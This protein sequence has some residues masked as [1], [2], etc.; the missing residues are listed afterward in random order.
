MRPNLP[1]LAL[2]TDKDDARLAVLLASS[3]GTASW[4]QEVQAL[5]GFAW[6]EPRLRKLGKAVRR[7][8]D[9]PSWPEVATKAGLFPYR[10]LIL[11]S[12]TSTHMQDLLTA[13]ALRHGI[14]LQTE[15][16][17]Y[18]EP[19]M[20]V[21]SEERGQ[22]FDG[23][24]IVTDAV[25]W[26]LH[27]AA[28]TA[29]EAQHILDG[30][31][32][33]V[34]R[35]T[36]SVTSRLSPSVMFQ[37]L[38]Q[39]DESFRSSLDL[40]VEGTTRNL[41]ARFNLGLAVNAVNAG[42]MLLD[43]ASLASSVGISNW[44]AGRFKHIGMFPFAP[45]ALEFYADAVTRII[46]S[47]VGRSRRVLVLDLDN[48]L[49]GG[50]IGDDGLEGI[51]MAP[52]NPTGEAHRAVQQM[53]LDAHRRGIVLCVASKNTFDVAIEAFRSHPD[54]ILTEDSISL[55]KINWQDKATSIRD[56]AKSLDLG[57]DAFVFVD[58]NPAERMQVRAELPQ[59]A[60]PELPK[61][62]SDWPHVLSLAGYFEQSSL[63]AEDANRGA[64]YAANAKRDALREDA[65]DMR[66]FLASLDM[67]MQVRPFD[68]MGRARIAQLVAKSNQ[69]NLTTRRYSE[70]ELAALESDEGVITLQLRLKDRFGDNGMIAAVVAAPVSGGMHIDLWIMS[71]RVLAR[72]VEQATLNLLAQHCQE[73]GVD[74]LLG[75][76]I[77]TARN[78]IVRD[79]Y[80]TLGFEKQ[81]EMPDGTTSWKLSLAEF[82]PKDA[83]IV[84]V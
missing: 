20:W 22:D 68:A 21:A 6:S 80:Q 78:G 57:L 66:S 1:W 81:A 39:E 65:S 54:M 11:S 84:L 79:L 61:D 9:R 75:T 77:P 15:C 44:R 10:L 28:H 51:K 17:E 60:V 48:T 63:T 36:Q 3:D 25:G 38:P 56:M 19:E 8:F 71:C 73:R 40:G 26:G 74:T 70:A 29:D 27:H 46:A 35:I 23:T 2:P 52:G 37:T 59:V 24:L 62:V 7:L 82:A 41:R 53:A 43:V 55:F 72:E 64:Y 32:S 16:A 76:Y 12:E 4:L 67:E 69:F 42:I 13:T 49:W 45:T 31:L 18:V 5:A 83:S 30:A 14:V 47:R 34:K 58:D 33:R 50:V